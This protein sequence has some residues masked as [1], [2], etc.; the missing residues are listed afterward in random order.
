MPIDENLLERLLHE[1]EGAALDFKRDQY[2]FEGADER[3]KSELLKDILAF[4]NARRETAAHILIGVKEVR[5]GRSRVVGVDKHLD[6]AQ[7][8]QFVNSKTNRAIEFSYQ[9]FRTEGVAIGVIE[10]PV[11]ERPFYVTKRFGKVEKD[12]VYKRDGSS[13]AVASLDEIASMGAAQDVDGTPQLVL[14]WADIEKRIVLAS[15]FA[16]KTLFLYPRLPDDTFEATRQRSLHPL[17][18]YMDNKNYSSEIIAYAHDMAFFKPFGL[19]LSNRGGMARRRVRFVG[20]VQR[21]N[22]VGIL[23]RSSQPRRPRRRSVD[24]WAESIIPLEQQLRGRHDPQ[25]RKL[26]D[27]WEVVVDFGD[28]RPQDEV[29]TDSALFIGSA[30]GITKLEGE[31]RGDNIPEPV[32]CVLE[33]NIQV[34]KRPMKRTDVE[35]YLEG[36]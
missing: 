8:H 11:Q 4:S 36:C 35:P 26:N 3:T 22:A 23:D 13:T 2:P 31:L 21:Q 29:W 10:I 15:P 19:R 17:N 18:T 14:E 33:I 20:W 24:S 12:T 7:L 32:S 30:G 16:V 5:G 25:V 34:E 27:K 28:V 6:D 9:P 1:E